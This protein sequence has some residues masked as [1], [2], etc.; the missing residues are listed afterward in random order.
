MKRVSATHGLAVAA[1]VGFAAVASAQTV[2]GL[3]DLVGARGSSAESELQARGYEFATNLGS[4]ALWWN[5]STKTCASVAVDQGRVQSIQTASASDCG[6]TES[7]G[8]GG[9]SGAS[10]LDDLV[11]ARGSSAE[12]ALQARGYKLKGHLGSAALWWN[13]STKSCVSVAVD[14]GRVQSIVKSAASD[15]GK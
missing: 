2:P 14:E 11:G 12:S 7:H 15:C 8:S 6:K 13:P 10:G 1:V 9:A 5:A 3:G 4:A